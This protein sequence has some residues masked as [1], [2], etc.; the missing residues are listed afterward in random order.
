MIC[1]DATVLVLSGS[2]RRRLTAR[3]T[4][5]QPDDAGRMPGG[6]FVC[7]T[8]QLLRAAQAASGEPGRGRDRR[9]RGG[10]HRPKRR[11][12]GLLNFSVAAGPLRMLPIEHPGGHIQAPPN[13]LLAHITSKNAR[14]SPCSTTPGHRP[15]DRATD[16]APPSLRSMGFVAPSCTIRIRLIFHWTRTRR[17]SGTRS[18]PGN[19]ATPPLPGGLR[20]R[21]VRV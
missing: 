2:P 3:P 7:V 1:R 10:H 15:P 5:R 21:Y 8:S 11:R 4:S 12:I 16:K 9:G 17:I 18:R 19:I 13:L 14:P 20:H 6:I